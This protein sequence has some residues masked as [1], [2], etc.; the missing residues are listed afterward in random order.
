MF[1]KNEV[2][3]VMPVLHVISHSLIKSIALVHVISSY[4]IIL[5]IIG[6]CLYHGNRR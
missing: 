1:M 4:K 3:V 5:Q 2:R 6:V